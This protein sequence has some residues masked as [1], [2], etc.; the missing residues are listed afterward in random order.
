MKGFLYKTV[1]AEWI[2]HQWRTMRHMGFVEHGPYASEEEAYRQ[3]EILKARELTPHKYEV[4]YRESP[5]E[6]DP[7]LAEAVESISQK[8][9]DWVDK[10]LLWPLKNKK[11]VHYVPISLVRRRIE[12]LLHSIQNDT[13]KLD[14][15][16]PHAA[17]ETD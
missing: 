2:V 9:K 3:I 10:D 5:V 8:L 17:P 1:R 4:G 14:L 12:M 13:F 6:I 15:E 7:I 11:V 16:N